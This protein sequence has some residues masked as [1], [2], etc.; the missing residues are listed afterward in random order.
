V[1]GEEYPIEDGIPNLLPP[2]MRGKRRPDRPDLPCHQPRS[3]STSTAGPPTLL[4]PSST[5]LETDDSFLLSLSG[6]ESPAH[7]HCRLAGDLER[8]AS[9]EEANYFVE[10]DGVTTVPIAVN[11]DV[12]ERPVD[13]HLEV[14]TGYGS[15][16]ISIAVTVVPG[17]PDVDVVDESSPNPPARSRADD[18]RARGRSSL[19]Y[20][21]LEPG[22]AGGAGTGLVSV[23][24]AAPTAASIGSPVVT[25]GS[26]S[27][28]SGFAVALFLLVQ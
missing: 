12:I 21:G 23:G 15:E 1:C 13:G 5:S 7:V 19:R 20:R 6:H 16:S 18:A 14:L 11:A 9:L 22:N 17:P 25:A 8:I 10:P 4:E 3:P 24:I 2:D 27:S 28:S 26:R